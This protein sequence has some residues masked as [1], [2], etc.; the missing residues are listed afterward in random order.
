VLA[1]AEQE[2]THIKVPANLAVH[3]FLFDAQ[4]TDPSPVPTT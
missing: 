1:G 3:F 2:V 4:A